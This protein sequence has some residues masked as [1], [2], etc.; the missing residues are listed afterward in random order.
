MLTF[1]TSL[2]G[3]AVGIVEKLTVSP[4][5]SNTS[6]RAN[7]ILLSVVTIREDQARDCYARRATVQRIRGHLDIGYW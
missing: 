5:V 2:V 6:I 4:L 3:G 7:V 1:E